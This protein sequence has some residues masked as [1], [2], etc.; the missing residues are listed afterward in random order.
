MFFLPSCVRAAKLPGISKNKFQSGIILQ[1]P[2][3]ARLKDIGLF[4]LMASPAAILAIL[5]WVLSAYTPYFK[6]LGQLVLGTIII[7][8]FL[9]LTGYLFSKYIDK[10]YLKPLAVTG[11]VLQSIL[12]RTFKPLPENT[13]LFDFQPV[14]LMLSRLQSS[15][16][17]DNQTLSNL[18]NVNTAEN[19]L[20]EISLLE[21]TDPVIILDLKFEVKFINLAAQNITGVQKMNVLGKRIDQFVRF[22]DKQNREILPSTY[23][24]IQK[25]SPDISANTPEIKI[26]SGSEIKVISNINRQAI[27]DISVYQPPQGEIVDTSVIILLQDRTKEKQLEA[28]KLDFV[29]MAAHELRTPLTSVKGYISVFLS[30]NEKKLTPEQLMFIRRINTSTQQLSGLVENLLS[31]ARVERGAMSLNTQVIDWVT[32]VASQVETFQH[33]ADE[34]R[35]NLIFTPPQGLKLSV[36]V[37]LVRINEVLNNIISNALT[38][39]EPQGRIEIWIDQKDEFIST[40]IKDTGKGI[41]KDVLPRLF[42]KFFRIQG[43]PAEQA[44]KGNGLGLYLSKAIIELHHGKIWAESEGFGR[45]STFSFSLPAV[46]QSF[47]IN[48]L[49]KAI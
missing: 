41:P 10:K 47:D 26:Y 13:N 44:S 35:I 27:A 38:Y 4:A 11:N 45:G 46:N 28:M 22:Y 42:S 8:P 18:T 5:A 7:L 23:A 14:Y 32:N 40:H 21:I 19:K 17:Q 1:M 9:S 2:K 33:R 39:T 12:S 34:K 29:S 15:L 31:V 6:S 25:K 30:E 37:D 36:Q 48:L 20:F 49:T 43:G 24:P 3:S 16:V